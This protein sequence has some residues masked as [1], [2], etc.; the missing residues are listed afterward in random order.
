MKRR[1]RGFALVLVIWSLIVL[2][3]LATGF[4]LAVRQ[5]IRVA[6]DVAAIARAEAVATAALHATALALNSPDPEAR[7]QAD[8]RTHQ[9]PWPDAQVSVRVSS[10]SGRIDLNRAPRELLLGLFE[11]FSPA[12]TAE[13]LTDALIDWRD[14]DDEAGPAGAEAREYARAGYRYGPANGPLN[15]VSELK[16]V[17]GFDA[18]IVETVMPY[19]TVHSRRP[20]I[21]VLSA[22]LVVLLSVPEMDRETAWT[23]IT[24]RE[25][26]LAEGGRMDLTA[27]RSGRRYLEARPNDRIL[28]VDID[29]RLDDGL[30]RRERAVIALN[31]LR[32]YLLLARQTRPVAPAGD[33]A[34]P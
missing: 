13:R 17:L 18:R 31:R 30:R 8:T 1:Q 19:L 6:G 7:W 5:E 12:E 32:G 11:Q 22:D 24:E 9:I 28:A 21:N 23:L 4:A 34:R 14:R 3:S 20:R 33:D 16:R 29:V 27:F 26:A 10:E 25:R 15:S 2:T